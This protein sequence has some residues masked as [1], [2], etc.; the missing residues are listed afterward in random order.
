MSYGRGP[1]LAW[2]NCLTRTTGEE[3]Y[4]VRIDLEE[5]E[6]DVWDFYKGD[7]LFHMKNCEL[8]EWAVQV[9]YLASLAD[10]L[11]PIWA[12][13]DKDFILVRFTKDF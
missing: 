1:A 8:P 11:S 7:S 6:V 10:N 12:A 5:G 9:S 4:L 3:A 2:L 13:L